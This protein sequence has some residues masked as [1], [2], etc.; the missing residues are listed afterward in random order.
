ME[1]NSADNISRFVNEVRD[2]LVAIG[3]TTS[4]RPGIKPDEAV[5]THPLTLLYEALT[6]EFYKRD[7][8]YGRSGLRSRGCNLDLKEPVRTVSNPDVETKE[9]LDTPNGSRVILEYRDNMGKS[10]SDAY[11]TTGI[12]DAEAVFSYTPQNEKTLFFKVT[13]D[14]IFKHVLCDEGIYNTHPSWDDIVEV[15]PATHF[16]RQVEWN[17]H[18]NR[19]VTRQDLDQSPTGLFFYEVKTLCLSREE[20]PKTAEVLYFEDNYINILD[21]IIDAESHNNTPIPYE[22]NPEETTVEYAKTPNGVTIIR[23]T[24]TNAQMLDNGVLRYNPGEDVFVTYSFRHPVTGNVHYIR[25]RGYA[26]TTPNIHGYWFVN[27]DE[28]KEV[29]YQTKKILAPTK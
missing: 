14:V 16:V 6:A 20:D 19:A 10:P 7:N 1:T 22:H 23:E 15:H 9:Y 3:K 21:D 2:T 29:H 25:W 24:Y 17:T 18:G 13:G 28:M 26:A 4:R 12:F 8:S 27:W 11:L 5:N